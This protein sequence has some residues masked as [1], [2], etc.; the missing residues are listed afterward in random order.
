MQTRISLFFIVLTGFVFN[1]QIDGLAQG[2]ADCDDEIPECLSELEFSG[3]EDGCACYTCEDNFFC[4]RNG[5]IKALLLKALLIQKDF[6]NEKISAQKKENLI[7][8]IN[9]QIREIRKKAPDENGG[10]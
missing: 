2:V 8:G 3:E 9:D 1:A 6:L 7:K 5:K 10:E 4:V